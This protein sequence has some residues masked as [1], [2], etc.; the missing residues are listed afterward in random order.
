MPKTLA[1]WGESVPDEFTF[2][3]KLSKAVIH[4]KGLEFDEKELEKFMNCV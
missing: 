2:T 4:S 3:F 1:R